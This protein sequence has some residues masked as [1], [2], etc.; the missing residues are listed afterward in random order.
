MNTHVEA[1]TSLAGDQF[2]FHLTDTDERGE[3]HQQQPS[4]AVTLS[5]GSVF[6][7]VPYNTFVPPQRTMTISTTGRGGEPYIGVKE[8]G[9]YLMVAT[10]IAM[11]DKNGSNKV[12]DPGGRVDC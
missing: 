11:W 12:F 10:D 5:L 4:F 9:D 2:D 6:C 7:N 8:K 1:T 3:E